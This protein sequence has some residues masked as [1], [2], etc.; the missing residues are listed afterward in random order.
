MVDLIFAESRF[1]LGPR[2]GKPVAGSDPRG[3]A[4]SQL[5]RFRPA[6]PVAIPSRT[7]V[8][9]NLI[10]L[11]EARRDMRQESGGPRQRAALADPSMQ[12]NPA[13]AMMT[14]AAMPK[15]ERSPEVAAAAKAQRDSY[16]AM[17]GARMQSALT[18]DTPFAERMVHFWANHFAVAANMQNT[19]G[20]GGL[21]EME[22]IRPHVTG[23][24]RDMLFAVEQ[25]P[26]MLYYL[27]QAQ[28]VGPNS[29]AGGRANRAGKVR[30]LNENLAREIMELHTLGVRTGYTQADV[31]E[32]ARALTGWTVGGMGRGPAGR[33]AQAQPVA[34]GSFIFNAGLHEPGARTIMGRRF[35]EGGEEQAAA[36]LDMFASHPATAR[37]VATKLARHFTGD[38]PPP[39]MVDRLAQAFTASGGDLPTVYRAIVASPEAWNSATPKFRDPWDWS[40]A[41]LRAMDVTSLSPAA[42]VQMLK[43][44]GQPVWQPPA[45]SG[46]DDIT[47][48]WAGP[49]ALMRRVEAA[50]RM[51]D[52]GG[53][54]I[55]ARA[56]APQ[57]LGSRLSQA[58]GTAIA[59]AESPKTGL[60]ILLASPEMLRR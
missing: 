41:A 32:F 28:S 36:V 30:G 21:L 44:L 8:A 6:L 5:G 50:Q 7:Q 9:E 25:H 40:V 12:A 3:W 49:D 1:G 56:L 4:D 47:A 22:A 19:T 33:M 14:P 60:A 42:T 24:F 20:F 29:P 59:R 15:P 38:T 45:P 53:Q 18:T 43:E 37:H 39:A 35:P 51:A 31:T 13:A 11:N 16:T 26:A 58:T 23:R 48:S 17:V 10:A 54:G 52:E 55:D 46:W 57:I 2:G 34:P 27:N